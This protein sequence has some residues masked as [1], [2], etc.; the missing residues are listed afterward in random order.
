MTPVEKMQRRKSKQYTD[1][2]DEQRLSLSLTPSELEL[3][4][5]SSKKITEDYLADWR[6]FC[7]EKK[8]AVKSRRNRRAEISKMEKQATTLDP[9]AELPPIQ[10]SY[11]DKHLDGDYTVVAAPVLDYIQT[12]VFTDYVTKRIAPGV[13]YK[14]VIG[15]KRSGY[16]DPRLT[17]SK[18]ANEREHKQP[19]PDPIAWQIDRALESTTL[20][21]VSPNMES[22][23]GAEGAESFD[24]GDP[25]PSTG[26]QQ[27]HAA[28]VMSQGSSRGG[29]GMAEK[30]R[31]E[32]FKGTTRQG[33]CLV[34]DPYTER[35]LIM[36]LAF[37]W[38]QQ[39]PLPASRSTDPVNG[40]RR[41]DSS[42]R[43][44]HIREH[45]C[46]SARHHIVLR[47]EDLRNINLSDC[48]SLDATRSVENEPFPDLSNAS[49]WDEIKVLSSGTEIHQRLALDLSTQIDCAEAYAL[50]CPIEEIRHLGRWVMTQMESY[51][52]P[53]VP[54]TP[55]FFMA[56]F[57]AS[58]PNAE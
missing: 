48:F 15:F 19:K 21:R 9:S 6:A 54:I 41:Y 7:D 58:E 28:S 40:K 55:A 29:K 46:I 45:F 38:C 34:R 16:T 13:T 17:P 3:R 39:A 18:P 1:E 20:E 5:L 31:D 42:S 27:L 57:L 43:F 47:D 51:Y 37:T 36:M 44:P 24:D 23:I 56:G 10:T 8:D 32:G 53:M 22:G 33:T 26:H 50:G 35:Q 49:N 4:K 12:Q 14:G 11:C 25:G 30:I 2:R 52:L